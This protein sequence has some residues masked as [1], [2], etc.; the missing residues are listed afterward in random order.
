MYLARSRFILI[1]DILQANIA[2][3]DSDIKCRLITLS[4]SVVLDLM[5]D[6]IRTE[7]QKYRLM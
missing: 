7:L 1:I 4:M 5:N 6:T 2:V 3:I